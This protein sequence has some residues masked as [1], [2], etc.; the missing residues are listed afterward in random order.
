MEKLWHKK[1]SELSETYDWVERMKTVHQSP[2][3]HAEG[4]VAIHTQMVL[5]ALETDELYHK[6]PEREQQIVWIAALFHD[7]EKYSTT[8]INEEG[9]IVSP[10]HAKRGAH[11]TR[12]ILFTDFDID[13][14]TRESI[15][16]LVRYHGLPLWITEKQ[17]PQK[18]LLEAA[19][20]TPMHL[21]A[22]LARADV[23]GRIC[24][25][26]EMLLEK[27]AF[28]EA[29]CKEQNV[30]SGC[31]PFETDA[32]KFY[33]FNNDNESVPEYLP[34]EKYGSEVV[35]MSGLPGMGKDFYIQKH[36]KDRPVICLDDIRKEMKAKPTDKTATGRA[37]QAAK[38]LAKT[39]LRRRERFVWNATNITGQMRMQLVGLLK[40]YDAHVTIVYIEMPYRV[41]RSQ[42]KQRT[43]SLPDSVLDKMLHK[44]EVPLQ[45]EADIVTYIV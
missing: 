5:D 23:N 7:V 45:K 44:L 37:V 28:F 14:K 4:N 39:Y 24:N 9:E 8:I 13:F 43:A 20:H 25:D 35:V 18:M 27:V 32:A 22:M 17:N 26:K 41:W 3:H 6:L 16:F 19:M 31:F 42:N 29:Y 30:W 40:D 11:T 10:G 38:E 33:Y 12:E 15:V 34:Y 36:Y 21:L 2:V 1:I